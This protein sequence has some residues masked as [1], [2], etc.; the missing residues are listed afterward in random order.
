MSRT[1]AG[2]FGYPGFLTSHWFKKENA[3]RLRKHARDI[4][5]RMLRDQALDPAESSSVSEA[6]VDI[7]EYESHKGDK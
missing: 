4:V 5:L 1:C 3:S 6:V 7:T 2:Q